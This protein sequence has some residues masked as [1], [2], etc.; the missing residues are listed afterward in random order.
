MPNPVKDAAIELLAI[1]RGGQQR[2]PYTI[3][4]LLQ[5]VILQLP[6]DIPPTPPVDVPVGKGKIEVIQTPSKHQK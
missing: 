4:T 5:E 6:D 2:G 3:I 1:Y